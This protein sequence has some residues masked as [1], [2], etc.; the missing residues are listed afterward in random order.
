MMMRPLNVGI[1][2]Y[3]QI[4]ALDMIGPMKALRAA[5]R[6]LDSEGGGYKTIVLSASGLCFTAETG[7]TMCVQ[8]ALDDARALDTIIVPGGA[9]LREEKIG[10]PIVHWL[11]TRASRTRRVVSICTGIYAL[12]DAGLLDGRRATTHWRFASDVARRFPKVRL[13][14]DALFVRD[15]GFYSSAGI[16]AG[17]DLALSLIEED[18][19]ERVALAARR[20][21]SW[22]ISS[23]RADRCN[24]PSRCSFRRAQS[25]AS[26]ISQ[27]G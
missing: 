27:A 2:G 24:S 7:L 10:A 16:A 11:R 9:G 3:D 6:A 25:T 13:E 1:V 20:A 18:F 5:N 4:T 17:I 15:G 22:F 14:I 8:A 21:N 23:G 26:P 19:G 12:A